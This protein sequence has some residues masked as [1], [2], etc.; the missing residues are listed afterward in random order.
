MVR[1][2]ASRSRSRLLVGRT[3][4]EGRKII[5]GALARNTAGAR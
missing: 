1:A 4:R 5:A 3:E 2:V